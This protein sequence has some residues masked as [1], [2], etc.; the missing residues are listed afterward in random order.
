MTFRDYGS[1]DRGAETPSRQTLGLK[2]PNFRRAHGS[3]CQT[4]ALN[5][6]PFRVSF[7]ETSQQRISIVRCRNVRRSSLP[8]EHPNHADARGINLQPGNQGATATSGAE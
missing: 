7:R 3:P 5:I 6:T 1:V 4:S 2:K 8:W